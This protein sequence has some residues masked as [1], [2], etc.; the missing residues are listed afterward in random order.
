MAQQRGFKVTRQMFKGAANEVKHVIKHTA[1]DV[2]KAEGVVLAKGEKA[3]RNR[4]YHSEDG[5]SVLYVPV[6]LQ[7]AREQQVVEHNLANNAEINLRLS[8]N[9]DS[10]LTGD[11]IA[12]DEI[13]KALGVPAFLNK[14]D[15]EMLCKLANAQGIGVSV[16]AESM[17]RFEQA[18]GVYAEF[19]A[20][21]AEIERGVSA[22]EARVSGAPASAAYSVPQPSKNSLKGKTGAMF[23]T[24]C[25]LKEDNARLRREIIKQEALISNARIREQELR[26]QLINGAVYAG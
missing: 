18:S 4:W 5:G 9:D 16:P 23:G 7:Q 13:I 11:T 8:V 22:L 14:L 19:D 6:S 10:H 1:A 24:I 3:Q 17:L 12:D 25:K 26:I 15:Y 2:L 20:E 21:I